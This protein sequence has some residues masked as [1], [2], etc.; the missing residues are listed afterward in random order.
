MKKTSLTKEGPSGSTKL[1]ELE[2]EVEKLK[3]DKQQK[4]VQFG[5]MDTLLKKTQQ[6]CKDFKKKY[7]DAAQEVTPFGIYCN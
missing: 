7:E 5:Q 6:E 3:K 2:K 4:L 1:Q